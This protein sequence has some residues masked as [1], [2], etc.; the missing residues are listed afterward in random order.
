MGLGLA[1]TVLAAI[2]SGCCLVTEKTPPPVRLAW[3]ATDNA[4]E[5]IKV[6]RETGFTKLAV[7]QGQLPAILKAANGRGVEVYYWDSNTLPADAGTNFFRQQMS[8]AENTAYFTLKTAKVP[9]PGQYQFGGEP[10]AGHRD[11]LS[12]E[13]LC[14]HHQEV[15][16]YRKTEIKK[17]LRQHPGV[18]GVAFDFYGY[19]NYHCCHCQHS[20]RL[21][22]QTLASGKYAGLSREKAWEQFSLDTLV[23]FYNEMAAYVRSLDPNLKTAAHVYPVFQAEPLYGNRLDIDYCAQTVAWFFPPY[24]GEDKIVRYT[25]EVVNDATRYYPRQAGIPFIGMYVT[26]KPV[27]VFRRELKII[28]ANSNGSLSLC[29]FHDVVQDKAYQQTIIEE[30]K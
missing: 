4:A 1:G 23:A 9:D 26:C 17:A 22:E 20:V 16:A 27:D 8:E 28:R 5:T 14:F 24:W 29:G 21:F 19:Q 15:V 12:C 11:V 2:L 30:M 10:L 18:A 25:R 7:G 3:G 13:L 6:C